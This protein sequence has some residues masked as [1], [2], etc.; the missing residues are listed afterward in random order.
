LKSLTDAYGDTE[1]RRLW[2]RFVIHHTPKHG[3]WLN[4][5]E[6]EVSL[7]SRECA[8]R[9]RIA[10]LCELQHRTRLWAKATD[11]A[12]RKINWRFTTADARRVFK[13]RPR[14]D[15]GPKD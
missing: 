2:L 10:S 9:D 1:G 15:A 13:Y 4:P 8:G 11:R 5:A 7:W 14:H 6:I 12:R 3:S